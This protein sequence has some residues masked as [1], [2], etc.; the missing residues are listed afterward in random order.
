[1]G[2][3]HY[4]SGSINSIKWQHKQHQITVRKITVRQRKKDWSR[5]PKRINILTTFYSWNAL[6]SIETESKEDSALHTTALL[7]T[8]TATTA[9][10]KHY[11]T[12]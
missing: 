4:E 11:H 6:N 7:Y 8:A 2:I 9:C 3:Y 10:T 5:I 12:N 1:M